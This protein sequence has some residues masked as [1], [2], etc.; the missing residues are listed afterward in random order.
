MDNKG[1]GTKAEMPILKGFTQLIQALNAL[2]DEENP[3][4]TT[5]VCIFILIKRICRWKS[6]RYLKV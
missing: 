2:E 6:K 5:T 3:L 1:F 4:Q